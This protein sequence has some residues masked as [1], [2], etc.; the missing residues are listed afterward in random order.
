MIR[1]FSSLLL[2]VLLM[3]PAWASE[4]GN[5]GYM[6]TVLITGSPSPKQLFGRIDYDYFDLFMR[7][8]VR[9]MIDVISAATLDTS[10]KWYQ[11]SG[12]EVSF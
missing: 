7:T 1:I 4:A 11:W 5:D 2:A 12:E 10:G 9:G 3:Q 6:P 8:N